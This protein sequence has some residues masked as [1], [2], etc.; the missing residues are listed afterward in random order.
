M[1]EPPGADDALTLTDGTN[2]R[3]GLENG[4]NPEGALPNA[5]KSAPGADGEEWLSNPRRSISLP[6]A[7]P[8][9]PTLRS[10]L[11]GDTA[12]LETA[13]ATCAGW[14]TTLLPLLLLLPTDFPLP[15]AELLRSLMT[16]LNG[17]AALNL[18]L[19]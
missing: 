17:V 1:G 4:S 7:V 19:S 15:T 11:L 18:P 13:R 6:L 10:E 5:P 3:S 16:G 2:A 14:G 12:L 9:P 8:V